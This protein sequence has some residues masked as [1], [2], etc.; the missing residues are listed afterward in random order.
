MEKM[1]KGIK[2]FIFGGRDNRGENEENQIPDEQPL[3]YESIVVTCSG[4][5]AKN[6]IN[7]TA[8]CEYCGSPLAYVTDGRIPVPAAVVTTQ[9]TME[10]NKE[11]EH[12]EKEYLLSTGFYTAGIDIPEGVCNVTAI[13]G[14]GNITSSDFGINEIFGFDR[15]EVS[16][17]KGL[18]LQ[19]G[20]TLSVA[21]KVTIKLVYKQIHNSC[22]G[23]TY[24]MSGSIELSTGNYT[25]GKDF[26]AGMYN[27]AAVSG[28]GNLSTGDYEVI[29][30]FGLDE[31]DIAEI[32]NVSIN[33]GV[34]LSLEGKLTVR[35]I[36]AVI[37]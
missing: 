17:Y 21:R 7:S 8:E 14:S 25:A 18:K 2:G 1:S 26:K 23:R 3:A 34:E 36:P 13:S 35:L 31:E 6:I 29:E 5:G 37:N 16:S 19:K 32:K 22:T 27:I 30:V 20:V 9:N 4:C 28:T 33:Q 24:N 10:P 12:I 15:D 11:W